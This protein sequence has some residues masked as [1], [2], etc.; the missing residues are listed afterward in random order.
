MFS[1][2]AGTCWIMLGV[3]SITLAAIVYTGTTIR[4][5]NLEII[6][7]KKEVSDLDTKILCKENVGF[8]LADDKGEGK[9]YLAGYRA[10]YEQAKTAINTNTANIFE[11]V[12]ENG[13]SYYDGYLAGYYYSRL[14][15]E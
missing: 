8:Q 2:N 4:K 3:S 5:L 1:P 9:E 15:L 12:E 11:S 14:L 6:K 10:G 7:T 13:E